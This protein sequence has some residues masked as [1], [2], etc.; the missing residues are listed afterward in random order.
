MRVEYHSSRSKWLNVAA[1][2][3]T[4]HAGEVVGLF[5][6]GDGDRTNDLLVDGT[7]IDPKDARALYQRFGAQYRVDTSTSL[8]DYL[9]GESTDGFFDRGFPRGTF[10]VA[11]MTPEERQVA[12]K[13]CA[14]AGVVEQPFLDACLVDFSLTQ[15]EGFADAARAAQVA[16]NPQNHTVRLGDRIAPGV[17]ANG[18]GVVEEPQA[19]DVYEFEGR[20]GQQ[21]FIDV[22][23]INGIDCDDPELQPLDLAW[24]LLG[25]AGEEVSWWVLTSGTTCGDLGPVELPATGG[26]QLRVGSVKSDTD[27]TG[28]YALTVW[29]APVEEFAVPLG[30][31][32]KPGRPGPGAGE[33]LI[34]GAVDVYEFEGRA[35]QQVFIDVQAINGIDCDDPELQPLD[36]AWQLL[37]PA[38]EEVSWWVL[39]SGTTCGDLGPVELPATGG[40]QLR[41]GSVKS[42]TDATGSYALTVQESS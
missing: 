16:A 32:I 4:S 42:D 17:P 40:Y 23:A 27:A 39:T 11:D 30:T 19:V 15:D 41:V 2:L 8:F 10:T 22:Q 12:S 25:P 28:S 13:V 31:P 33:I 6:D 1:R 5:G 29:G 24:Q 38:G 20:A 21:V 3:A 9:P 18:A 14:D 36:L 35:G 7:T 26:Y 37:G 34:P